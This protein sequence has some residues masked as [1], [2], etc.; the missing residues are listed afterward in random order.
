[1]ELLETA[2]VSGTETPF[3]DTLMAAGERTEC[4]HDLGA[5]G[6]CNM[7]QYAAPLP[8]IYQNFASVAGVEDEEV[9]SL[10][11]SVTLADFCPFVQE[12]TWKGGE[13]G[14]GRGR[15]TRCENPD[16][17]PDTD[18]NYALEAYGANSRCFKQVHYSSF[19]SS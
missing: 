16:N 1:M 17:A 13:E 19:S 6:S 18:N 11:S 4:T 7:V 15:G 10:G 2:R 12:F 3:C 14:S 5:V 8:D 9:A